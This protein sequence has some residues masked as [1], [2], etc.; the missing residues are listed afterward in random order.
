MRLSRLE[1]YQKALIPLLN[2]AYEIGHAKN[3]ALEPEYVDDINKPNY[4]R[5]FGAQWIQKIRI[6]DG[7]PIWVDKVED[8]FNELGINF[9]KFTAEYTA[10]KPA[11]M[12]IIPR[13]ER[14]DFAYTVFKNIAEDKTYLLTYL[15]PDVR[16]RLSEGEVKFA[17]GVVSFLGETHPFTNHEYIALF[18]YLWPHRKV[19][20][21]DG[22]IEPGEPKSRAAVIRAT[23]LDDRRI[24]AMAVNVKKELFDKGIP[25]KLKRPDKIYLEIT[26]IDPAN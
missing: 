26:M 4:Q 14:F 9:R 17:G 11:T 22:S 18:N 5:K 8:K 2:E 13:N 7:I 15:E 10:L 19:L 25:V 20:R 3:M 23:G 24:A 12:K 16:K 6:N 1:D 21:E